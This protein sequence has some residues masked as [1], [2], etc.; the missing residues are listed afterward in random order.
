MVSYIHLALKNDNKELKI[1]D[2]RYRLIEISGIHAADFVINDTSHANHDGVFIYSQ[3]V[4]KR[5]ITIKFDFSGDDFQ[6]ARREVISFFNPK[7]QGE[8]IIDYSGVTKSIFYVVSS[9]DLQQANV[10]QVPSFEVELMCPDPYFKEVSD[11]KVDIVKW[12]GKFIFPLSIPQNNGVVF[13][14][15]TPNVMVNIFNEGDV[16]TGMNIKFM[17]AGQVVNP[18]LLN[19]NTGEFIK[20][21]KTLERGEVVTVNTHQGN[22]KVISELNSVEQNIFNLFTYESTFF[23]LDP[24]DNIFRYDADLNLEN[25]EISIYYN[26]RYLGV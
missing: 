17:A 25:L 16:S 10:Y 4:N 22:K 20:I 5:Y 18:S 24:G 26:P 21:E 14:V 7:K 15:K 2:D 3:K 12:E 11:I 13:G 8:L 23:Q 1:D 9:L 19:V 6:Q